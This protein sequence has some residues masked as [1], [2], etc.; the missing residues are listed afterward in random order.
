MKNAFMNY[1]IIVTVI[2]LFVTTDCKKKETATLPVLSTTSVTNIT[3]TT[4]ISGGNIISDGGTAIITNGVCW[5]TNANPSTADSK[6]VDGLGSGQF[7]SILSGLTTG[8]TYHIRAYATNSVGTGYGTDLSFSTLAQAPTCLTQPA[9]NVVA[10]VATLNGTVNA[11]NISATVTFEYGT[12]RSYGSTA[13][14]T[15]SPVTGNNI[16]NV[17]ADIA[18]L[19][20]ST[21]YHFRVK[22]VNSFGTTYG[23][24]MIFITLGLAPSCL[25]QPASNVLLSEATLN[26]SVNANNLSATVTFEYGTTTSYGSTAIATQSPI[27]GNNI[28]TI[29]VYISGLTL[30]TTYH[31]RAKAVNS[32]GTTYGSDLTFTTFSGTVIDINLNIYN[33]ITIGTQVW[34]AENLKT[35]KYR[36]GDLISTTTPATLDI[37]G[38]STP[39]YQWS[40]DGNESNIYPYGRLYTWYVLNDSRAICPTG[41]HVPTYAEWVVLTTYLGGA[42]IAAAKLMETGTAHW[43]SHNTGA[44]NETNFTALPGGRR[45]YNGTF[46]YIGRYGIWWSATED[47]ATNAWSFDMEHGWNNVSHGSD[48]K[49]WGYSIRCLK[50]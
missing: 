37:T 39:K 49:R 30:G 2:L 28:T 45:I 46:D 9:T 29:S 43:Q 22:A 35:T 38:E 41:W 17:S 19:T 40:Y 34:M 31:F 12:T 27:T 10:S 26:G 16:T 8:A 44:T 5:N 47:D 11:N 24:D 18:G 14:S 32:S 42:D 23:I 4:A 36:N 25:T 13:T 7:V 15:Q 3:A 6:T 48:I 50:D 20:A 1:P 21:T 33:T